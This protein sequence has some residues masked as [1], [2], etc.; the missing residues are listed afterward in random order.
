[1]ILVILS[2]KKHKKV[3]IAI[4][5]IKELN[6]ID[7]ITNLKDIKYEATISY[8]NIPDLYALA[9][10]YGA[11]VRY[12]LETEPETIRE[13]FIGALDEIIKKWPDIFEP[14]PSAYSIYFLPNYIFEVEITKWKTYSVTSKLPPKFFF[15]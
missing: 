11:K 7:P 15:L 10:L 5:T 4:I 3:A 2:N 12:L 1:M 6:E 8:E 13:L 9:L 14:K